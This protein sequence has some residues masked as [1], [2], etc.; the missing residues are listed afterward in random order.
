MVNLKIFSRNESGCIGWVGQK[1]NQDMNTC[2]KSDLSK[3]SIGDIVCR[4]VFTIEKK[5]MLTNKNILEL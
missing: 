4:M 1:K 2:L 5:N 3:S